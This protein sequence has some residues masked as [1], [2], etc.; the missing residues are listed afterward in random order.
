MGSFLRPGTAKRFDESA[1][2]ARAHVVMAR[3]VFS[4]YRSKCASSDA[5][6]VFNGK[7]AILGHF[8]G[9]NPKLTGSL[10]E[11]QFGATH[12]ASCT[13]TH[14]DHIFTARF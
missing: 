9:L 5:V 13:H 6:H 3:S 12:M 14:G 7:E 8:T 11:E 1:Q 2:P 4:N 10:V